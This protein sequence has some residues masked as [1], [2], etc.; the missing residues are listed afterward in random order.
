VTIDQALRSVEFTGRHTKHSGR[1]TSFPAGDDAFGKSRSLCPVVPARAGF[2][3]GDGSCRPHQPALSTLDAFD[4]FLLLDATTLS[5]G[6]IIIVTTQNR[7]DVLLEIFAEL[8]YFLLDVLSGFRLR[9]S[10]FTYL[11]ARA[12]KG[13]IQFLRKRRFTSPGLY[14]CIRAVSGSCAVRCIYHT[15]FLC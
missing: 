7:L 9:H 1:R 12:L 14:Q 4:R 2:Q 13:R 5:L 8:T 6:E 10:V 3:E 15:I 11:S